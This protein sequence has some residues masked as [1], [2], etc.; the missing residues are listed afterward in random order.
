MSCF[1]SLYVIAQGLIT[2]KG[3]T[4]FLDDKY[5]VIFYFFIFLK[6]F[7]TLDDIGESETLFTY[8]Q[9]FV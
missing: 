2:R 5:V 8:F 7:L 6:M 3:Y 1:T 9:F 4:L